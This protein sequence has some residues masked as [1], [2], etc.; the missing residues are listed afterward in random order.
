[1]N[2]P[3]LFSVPEIVVPETSVRLTSAVNAFV[4]PNSDTIIEFAADEKVTINIS[5]ITMKP[6]VPEIILPVTVKPKLTE[7]RRYNSLLLYFSKLESFSDNLSPILIELLVSCLYLAFSSNYEQPVVAPQ[8]TH[9]R[10]LPLDTKV[11]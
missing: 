11:N 10:Q 5:M 1:M 4:P 8:L 7:P 3:S 6:A 9:L 2:S